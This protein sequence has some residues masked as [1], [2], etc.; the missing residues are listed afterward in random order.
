M[1]SLKRK[2]IDVT[3]YGNTFVSA[4]VT[5][6]E[7]PIR[8]E[9]NAPGLLLIELP[10]IAQEYGA[11]KKLDQGV[12]KECVR[13]ILEKFKGI[14]INE[15][16]E[17]YRL[18]ASGFLEAPGAEMWGG[19][20]N[21][22]QLGKVLSAYVQHRRRI[23]AEYLKA[24]ELAAEQEKTRRRREEFNR[25][26]PAMIEAAKGRITDW[27]DVP[28]YWYQAAKNRGMIQFESGEAQDIYDEAKQLARMEFEEEQ[29]KAPITR[30]ASLQ[31]AAM[32][33]GD[34]FEFRAQVIAR[35]I[36]VF[37]KLILEQ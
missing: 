2:V 37:R 19:E 12:Q 30:K 18:K 31:A 26:F 35:K 15:I 24:K 13:L 10:Q 4:A 34:D 5:G 27:R 33:K 29:E 20:F 8:T 7:N 11:R 16:R 17:A 21:A 6:Y 23:I 14:G 25:K 9:E 32:G 3:G 1:P 36:T 28:E 22:D